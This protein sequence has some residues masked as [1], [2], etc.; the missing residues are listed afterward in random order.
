MRNTDGKKFFVYKHTSPSGKVYIGIT[1]RSPKSRWKHGSGYANNPYFT[2]AIEK[3]GW[4]NFEH[5]ILY[6]GLS[7]EEACEKE[8]SLIKKYD[9]SNHE[10]GYN[11]TTGGEYN[12]ASK[13]GR[14]RISLANKGKE[15][16]EE[17]R[18]KI[19]DARKGREMSDEAK[20]RLSDTRKAMHI[21]M[22]DEHKKK[23]IEANTGKDMSIETRDKIRQGLKGKEKSELHKKRLSESRKGK[24]TGKDNSIAEAVRC[25]ETGEIF[26]C[27][28]DADRKLQVAS[29]S[30]SKC[31]VGKQ[32]TV[33]GYHFERV[34]EE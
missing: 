10:K 22:S 23:I 16:S 28:R 30:V 3:Y 11:I 25:I 31:I 14:K 26:E 6:E 9:S 33:R 7:K 4:E 12:S 34:S 15:L 13:E 19:A 2:H 21:Q 20:K 24:Y 1:S 17:T 32:K 5:E 18:R 27:M 8:I 29:G